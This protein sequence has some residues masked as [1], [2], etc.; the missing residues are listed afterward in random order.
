MLNSVS[1][2]DFLQYHDKTRCNSLCG[3]IISGGVI[4]ILVLKLPCYTMHG[5]WNNAGIWANRRED[6]IIV[7][8]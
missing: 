3:E 8:C 2:I 4:Q 7:S 1:N 6:M 5:S